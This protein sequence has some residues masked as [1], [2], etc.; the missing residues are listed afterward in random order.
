MVKTDIR[1]ETLRAA[2]AARVEQSARVMLPAE[3]N[4]LIDGPVLQ[5]VAA[6]LQAA[7]PVGIDQGFLVI[8]NKVT[9]KILLGIL[10]KKQPD[11]YL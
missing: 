1:L 3:Q 5:V 4:P 6:R 8:L 7:V 11:S 9:K 10:S 2:S